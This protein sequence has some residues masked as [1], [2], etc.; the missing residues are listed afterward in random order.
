M[1][2]PKPQDLRSPAER[3][4]A[5]VSARQAVERSNYFSR[6]RGMP[7]FGW[8][9]ERES[10]LPSWLRS[11]K[12]LKEDIA[13]TYADLGFGPQHVG[14]Q[15]AGTS[16][17]LERM[18]EARL[19]DERAWRRYVE[20]GGTAELPAVPSTGAGMFAPRQPSP[21]AQL[22]GPVAMGVGYGLGGPIGG[23]VGAGV[24]GQF[25]MTQN[26][27]TGVWQRTQ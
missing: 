8:S 10:Y 4:A 9:T 25:G 16:M 21:F 14:P 12:E 6:L 3:R 19:G 15:A 23:A 7:D 13:G 26:P 5:D 18:R 22:L 11:E 17:A 2:S 20:S 1:T 24:G 27:Y